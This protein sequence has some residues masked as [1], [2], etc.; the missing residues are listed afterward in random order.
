MEIEIEFPKLA[1][2][3]CSSELQPMP[4]S[5]AVEALSSSLLSPVEADY[6]A[7]FTTFSKELEFIMIIDDL[8]RRGMEHIQTLYCYRS[9]SQAIPEIST[10]S[11]R[12]EYDEELTLEEKAELNTRK[13]EI[14]QKIVDLLRSEMRKIRAI[15][16]YVVDAINAFHSCLVHLA[17]KD[18]HKESIPEG[19]YLSLIH[20][21]DTLIILD[22][23]KDVKGCL[24]KDFSRYK[25]ALGAHPSV[26]I[27][28]EITQLQTFLAGQD[29]RKSRNYIFISLRD[30]IKRMNDHESFLIELLDISVEA[31]EEVT[32]LLPDEKFRFFRVLPYLVVMIDGEL[33]D[34]KTSNVFKNG[35]VKSLNKVQKL[36]KK[37]PV[38]PLFADT[39]LT[40]EYVLQ[41]AP[42]YEP[43]MAT[44]WCADSDIKTSSQYDISSYWESIRFSHS[45]YMVRFANAKNRYEK[46]PFQKI[47][48]E[49]SIEVARDV[50]TLVSEGLQKLS[51][52]SMVVRQMLCWKY[53]HPNSTTG[54]DANSPNASAEQLEG[55]EYARVL[56]HNLSSAELSILADIISMIKSLA[57][58]L[59][60]AESLFAP[61]IRFHIHHVTQQ[62]VQGDLTP[63]LH[64]VDKR[65]KP[66]LPTLLK[67]RALAADW[68]HGIEPANDY[69]EYSRKQGSVQSH[70]HP[71]RVVAPALSQLFILRAQVASLCDAESEVRKKSSIFS[72]ADLER[73]DIELFEKFYSESFLFP[74][75][76]HYTHYVREM[77]DL[78]D[79]W[80][81]EFFLE[82]T[83][84]VQ[85]PIDLS[86]PWL[87]VE[88]VLGQAST[89]P[90]LLETSFY[91]L[92]TYND[93]ANRA[94]Y[95]FNQQFIY[96][97][98]E[99][100]ANL[101]I[102]QFYFLLAD[103]IYNYYKNS[104]ASSIL[105]KMYKVRLEELKGMDIF[106][107]GVNRFET[108]LSQKSI[109]L[110]GR[111]INLSFIFAQNITSKFHRDI[112]V[113][114]KR[115]ESFDMRGIVELTTLLQILRKTHCEL[116]LFLDLD[117]F[118]LMLQEVDESFSPTSYRGRICL[119]ILNSLA[120]DIM[121]NFSY[122]AYTN[123]FVKAPIPV[124]PIEY[125]KVPKQ[126]VLQQAYGSMCFKAFESAGKLLKGFF[127][128]PHIDALISLGLK[129]TNLN[130]LID[131]L[132]KNMYD[133]IIDIS[134]YLEALKEGIP[135][136]KPPQAIFKTVGAYGYYEGKLR[137]ILSYDD[138]KPEVFQTFREIGN[139]IAFLK[140]LSEQLSVKGNL[141][142]VI[143]A[144]VLG[145]HP[146]ITF[147]ENE[148]DSLV[149]SSPAVCVVNHLQHNL[150]SNQSLRSVSCRNE[151]LLQRIPPLL[152][153]QVENGINTVASK[154]GKSLIKWVFVQIEEFLYQQ[155]LTV[156]WSIFNDH[157]NRNS[158]SHFAVEVDNPKGFARL[159]SALSFLFCI[160]EDTEDD[161][162]SVGNNAEDEGEDYSK[163]ITNT[164]E[165]GHGFSLSGCMFIHLLGQRHMFELLD[166]S[167][168][169]L[170]MQ[171]FEVN[172]KEVQNGVSSID[173]KL[174]DE[175][176]RF[177]RN[178]TS[179]QQLKHVW[180]SFFE[181]I[182]ESRQSYT[183]L[184]TNKTIFH[185]PALSTQG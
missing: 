42:H 135:P 142:Y 80:Y 54:T 174:V 48:D 141:D 162:S 176:K 52:W 26:E 60:Q 65:N 94:L 100:E 83:R 78:S 178:A 138:L 67:L 145:I 95:S 88:H 106:R 140:D 87:L 24:Q 14:N 79:L 34:G 57:S 90:F 32:Y 143:M 25:R 92:D 179:E 89:N 6:K 51:K 85:F 168:L 107:T 58:H 13:I 41:L 184:S 144:P 97:E 153:R 169:V 160:E 112:D 156:D 36:M 10:D 101:A 149:Q 53:T 157:L 56:K 72:K 139:A 28:E 3:S 7:Y 71:A 64:R 163:N 47:M 118:D 55:L 131:Q 125:P 23:L 164:A 91:L 98:I 137:S 8:T 129:L 45:Q 66:I 5:V 111:S 114:I 181:T 73:S 40:L 175:S 132:L 117:D 116:S 103:E 70:A 76:L 75:V 121:P 158:Q 86:L 81:R 119:H 113:A 109:Q 99:A 18:Q 170:R 115:F 167:S 30:E 12:G 21:L 19:L 16:S 9:V 154:E 69:K 123:R 148:S 180:F 161:Q 61:F 2:A 133:K 165:F 159:W 155:N 122:N 104:A 166:F 173:S 33:D 38:V 130:M 147:T 37:F 50:F 84:C 62:L 93:A 39:S 127:G 126:A 182:H 151:D 134:E 46:Y 15:I 31:L 22:S 20:L 177:V 110:L 105:D 152:T 96:D 1:M 183:K 27:L 77:S 185:P 63:L 171:E 146:H 68:L 172:T 59:L 29:A 102:D 17:F 74:Y 120:R 35:K 136:C 150:V 4:Q 128:R 82:M 44:N 124:R 108:I 49:V 11:H 43:G